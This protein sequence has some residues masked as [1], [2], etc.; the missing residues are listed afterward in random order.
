M[1]SSLLWARIISIA[2]PSLAIIGLLAFLIFSHSHHKK[3]LLVTLAIMVFFS[4]DTS[5][6]MF[7]FYQYLFSTPSVSHQIAKEF[8]LAYTLLWSS[9]GILLYFFV[10][11][12]ARKFREIPPDDGDNAP[13][14]LLNTLV[15]SV[16]GLSFFLVISVFIT[17]PYLAEINR[18]SV[19]SQH[20]LDS[21]LYTMAADTLV[22][23]PPASPPANISGKTSFDSHGSPQLKRSIDKEK[24]KI[25]EL[26]ARRTNAV[27]HLAKFSGDYKHYEAFATENLSR[28]F[29]SASRNIRTSRP[30]LFVQAVDAFSLYRKR[31][32][33]AYN[34]TLS[35]IYVADT[36]NSAEL[37]L[38]IKGL[39]PNPQSSPTVRDSAIQ[40]LAEVNFVSYPD[41]GVFPFQQPDIMV[42]NGD[43]SEWGIFVLISQYLI[44][45]QS[46]ELV[47]LVGMLGFG[48]L[49]AS[50]S[51]FVTAE[52][53][54][55]LFETFRSKPLV[56]NFGYVLLRGFGAAIA[57]YLCT[58]AGLAI[59]T[60]GSATS[61][62]NASSYM[63]LLTC[64][65]ASIYSDRVWTTLSNSL[66]TSSP[67]PDDAP[68]GA[69]PPGAPTVG[70]KDNPPPGNNFSQTTAGDAMTNPPEV[71]NPND[72]N[73]EAPKDPPPYHQS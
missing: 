34:Q 61:S 25:T 57:V 6:R 24:T 5:Q 26:V 58:K 37:D 16:L 2:I 49:G 3:S 19:Y 43:G 71:Y 18:P 41:S 13:T 15:I 40:Q 72:I 56:D 17:I 33:D 64:F 66:T 39:E 47:L 10:S 21:T 38:F 12:V 20:M 36:I 1:S 11:Y 67:K 52:D 60:M 51:S 68:A 48:L 65:M 62:D 14:T 32:M 70:G 54:R 53:N 44:K 55:N 27:A 30:D 45:T 4:G 69:P 46:S 7:T 42:S 31:A 63:L 73:N 29:A 22:F 8:P 23:A 59:F 9:I 50:L 28:E 35:M